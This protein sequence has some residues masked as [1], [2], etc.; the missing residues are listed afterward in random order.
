MQSPRNNGRSGKE[1]ERQRRE[2]N[3]VLWKFVVLMGSVFTAGCGSPGVEPAA[4][5]APAELTRRRIGFRSEG[6]PVRFRNIRV[7]RETESESE[8][9]ATLGT[10]PVIR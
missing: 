8:S 7:H 4:E 2:E 9:A 3:V 10:L 5:I 6:N 1:S